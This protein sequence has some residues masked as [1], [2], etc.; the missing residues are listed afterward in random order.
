M[1]PDEF[2]GVFGSADSTVPAQS[3]EFAG[4]GVGGPGGIRNSRGCIARN[5]FE[6]AGTDRERWVTSSSMPT[7]KMDFR[8]LEKTAEI[9]A[10]V[11]SLELKPY[12]PE[13]MRQVLPFCSSAAA[14]SR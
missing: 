3:P 6:G 2:D 4:N 11:V 7:V 8:V 12:L 5:S 10:G 13:K 9:C 1:Q 14:T